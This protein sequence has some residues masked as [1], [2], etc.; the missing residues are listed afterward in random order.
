MTIPT[1]S[2]SMMCNK[3]AKTL[4]QEAWMLTQVSE[5]LREFALDTQDEAKQIDIKNVCLS[6][7]RCLNEIPHVGTHATGRRYTRLQF[8]ENALSL[9]D[10]QLTRR[11]FEPWFLAESTLVYAGDWQPDS[12]LPYA[13][14]DRRL[15][16]CEQQIDNLEHALHQTQVALNRSNA[17]LRFVEAER[18]HF[19]AVA[20]ENIHALVRQDFEKSTSWRVT[21]PMRSLIAW[22]RGMRSEQ[23]VSNNRGGVFASKPST[24]SANNTL[25]SWE[26]VTPPWDKPGYST[27]VAWRSKSDDGFDRNNYTEWCKR[28]EH[29][30]SNPVLIAEA[31]VLEQQ[32]SAP[33]FSI[34]MVIDQTQFDFV[35]QSLA[36]VQ[37]QFYGKWELCIAISTRTN[38]TVHEFIDL[39]SQDDQRIKFVAVNAT[40]ELLKEATS[41]ASGTWEGILFATNYIAPQATYSLAKALFLSVD[42]KIIY[43]DSDKL[44]S[45]NFTRCIPDFKPDWNLDLFYSNNYTQDL[46]FFEHE[47]IRQCG[48]FVVEYNDLVIASFAMT[49]R[50]IESIK[51]TQIY[52]VPEILVHVR[53]L[54]ETRKA[55]MDFYVQILNA[56]FLRTRQYAHALVGVDTW[57]IQYTLPTT[58]PLVSLIIPTRNNVSLLRQCVS[59]IL[60]KTHYA[61]FE[62]LIIDNG[63]DEDETLDYLRSLSDTAN[64]RLIRDNYAFNYSA[65][66]NSAVAL[67]KGEFIALVNDDIEVISPNW[68]S[69]MVSHALRPGI[70]A[71][72]AR[73]WYPDWRLQH[74]GIVL[75]GGVA[76]HVHKFLPAGEPGFNDRAVRIQ[77]FSA[78]TGACLVVKKSLF[79][80]L[81]G[82]NEKELSI[83][84][85][86]VDFC[87]RLIEAG[88]RNVWTP[89]AEL[90]HHE[91]ATRGQDDSTDKQRRAEKEYRYMRKRWGAKM[92]IDPAYNPNLSSGHDDFSLA[93]P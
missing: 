43:S 77:N 47:L 85:N 30:A 45:P 84:F 70:G 82:L 9:A 87:L 15:L 48:G 23:K 52:H 68:L 81:G 3:L 27:Q 59:S 56:H 29:R 19:M 11:D 93:W 20:I 58:P 91:S 50:A 40:D 39:A 22:A 35:K 90:I 28:Y 4:A 89:F 83:G 63:S 75:A 72:G 61:N 66:N 7:L 1:N 42:M 24:N 54:A 79:L 16:D 55:E 92:D 8:I 13:A 32:T 51:P 76:R 57:H 73:L 38:K 62:I 21:K 53:N 78:V 80:G 67:A 17:E 33:L 5:L 65:L 10:L 44:D 12:L 71:V 6:F 64:V 60:A 46:C 41:L 86:D 26:S 2:D 34:L 49:L 18:K 88:Y 37:A 69:E 31:K 25:L 36:S 14:E 74:A